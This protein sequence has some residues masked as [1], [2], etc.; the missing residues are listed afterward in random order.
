M[1]PDDKNGLNR[2]YTVSDKNGQEN[3]VKDD[4]D[5]VVDVSDRERQ[6]PPVPPVPPPPIPTS[7]TGAS[8]V[9]PAPP[10]PQIPVPPP[11]PPPLPVAANSQKKIE[12]SSNEG[13][14]SADISRG[15]IDLTGIQKA[16]SVLKKAADRPAKAKAGKFFG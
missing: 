15:A 5:G 1:K 6:A 13:A 10:P 14:K 8:S 2:T 7:L 9:P 11:P 16:R 12:S 3:M 4:V